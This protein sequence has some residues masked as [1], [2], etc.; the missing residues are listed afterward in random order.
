MSMV[1]KGNCPRA[2][3]I[4]HGVWV[5]AFAGTTVSVWNEHHAEILRPRI[6]FP[7]ACRQRAV[8]VAGD[9]ARRD[10]GLGR[11]DRHGVAAARGRRRQ[12]R[13]R[14]LVADPRT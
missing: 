2:L 10:P 9:H 7:L 4:R 6:L 11:A 12:D 5:P 14:V 13:R 8:S 1:T 3:T